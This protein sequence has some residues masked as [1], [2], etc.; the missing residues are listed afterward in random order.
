MVDKIENKIDGDVKKYPTLN[1]NFL[2]FFSGGPR[3]TVPCQ[4]LK[5]FLVSL[6]FGN[7]K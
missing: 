1:Y 7:L 6:A 3:Q 2:W 4:S 5:S